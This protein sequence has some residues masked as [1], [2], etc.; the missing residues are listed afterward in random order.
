[1]CI[2]NR[3]TGI[4]NKL[5]VTIRER[6]RKREKEGVRKGGVGTLTVRIFL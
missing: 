6:E 4:E 2:G 5:E 1:M 3:L